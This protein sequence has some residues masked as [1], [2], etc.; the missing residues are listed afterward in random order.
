MVNEGIDKDTCTLIECNTIKDLKTS[1]NFLNKILK[2][3]ISVMVCYQYLTNQPEYM[4]PLKHINF[5]L[6]IA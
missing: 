5:H 6:M 2:D 4:L 1:N 3:M